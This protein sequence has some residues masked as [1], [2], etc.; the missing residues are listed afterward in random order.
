MFPYMLS[1]WFKTACISKLICG[2]D[3]NKAPGPDGIHPRII[4]QLNLAIAPH[5]RSS[6]RRHTER[7]LFLRIGD[8]QIFVRF[9]KKGTGNDPANYRPIS[10]TCI[11]SKLFEHI[12]TSN[13][14]GHL[15]NHGIL[16]EKQHGFMKGRS[17]E[18]Q[19]LELTHGLLNS[20]HDGKQ[21]YL[22]VMDFAKAFDKVCHEKLVTT[23]HIYSVDPTT[24][25]WIRGFL[26]NRSH[27]WWSK[28][29]RHRYYLS[30]QEFPK[31][32][33]WDQHYSS[34]ILTACQQEY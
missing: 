30:L 15:V 7:E 13:F 12:A 4:R 5:F 16:Y 29:P 25:H 31:A 3:N 32:Q 11:A 2:L 1:L 26:S 27:Q 8:V 9:P 22:I 19:L 18:S 20:L 6:L 24:T 10:L 34:A 23:L 14:M 33:Y 21:T 28:E 17:C